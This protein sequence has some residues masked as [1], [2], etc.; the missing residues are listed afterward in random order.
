MGSRDPLVRGTTTASHKGLESRGSIAHGGHREGQ[1]TKLNGVTKVATG[2]EAGN[3]SNFEI[4]EIEIVSRRG[5]AKPRATTGFAIK[6]D[7]TESRRLVHR[8][9]KVSAVSNYPFQ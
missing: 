7:P 9:K 8:A 6:M 1:Q 4:L 2:L 3:N 5:G